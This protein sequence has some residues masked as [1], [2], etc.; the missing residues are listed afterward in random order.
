MTYTNLSSLLRTQRPSRQVAAVRAHSHRAARA[1]QAARYTRN[2]A[3]QQV[4]YDTLG[5]AL[6]ERAHA[7]L[8]AKEPTH[9]LTHGLVDAVTT[10]LAQRTGEPVR[11]QIGKA[12]AFF[13]AP[14]VK[15]S[16]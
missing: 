8:H 13:R 10:I 4:K 15:R 12:P 5:A 16:A 7:Y 6:I 14:A 9:Q 11:I 3:R 1:Q 2:P